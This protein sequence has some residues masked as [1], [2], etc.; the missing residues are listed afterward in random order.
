[1]AGMSNCIYIGMQYKSGMQDN[2]K[3]QTA[4]KVQVYKIRQHTTNRQHIYTTTTQVPKTQGKYV[5]IHRESPVG[6]GQVT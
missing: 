2:A 1:M 3:Q 4:Q 6:A 5:N